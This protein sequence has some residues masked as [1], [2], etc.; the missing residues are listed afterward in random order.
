MI[1]NDSYNYVIIDYHLV[2][3]YIPYFRRLTVLRSVE[4]DELR[5]R[6]RPYDVARRNIC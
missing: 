3:E 1:S 4:V 6:I 5:L 2:P